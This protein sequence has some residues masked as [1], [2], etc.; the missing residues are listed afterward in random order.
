[1]LPGMRALV[2]V[3][4]MGEGSHKEDGKTAPHV[5][6]R[7]WISVCTPSSSICLRPSLALPPVPVNLC[8]HTQWSLIFMGLLIVAE[9]WQDFP[10]RVLQT[11]VSQ[12]SFLQH[13][14]S[15]CVTDSPDTQCQGHCQLKG[16]GCAG[17]RSVPH[18]PPL[19]CSCL[20]STC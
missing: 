16:F 14:H 2:G 12:S 10:K 1:M 5:P 9:T 8:P 20:P 15:H 6:W 11:L 4:V 19:S 17:S 18:P 7:L 13:R 3:P